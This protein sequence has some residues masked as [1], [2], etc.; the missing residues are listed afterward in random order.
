MEFAFGIIFVIGIFLL[1][2]FLIGITIFVWLADPIAP[3]ILWGLVLLLFHR[4]LIRLWTSA[5][6]NFLE[7]ARQAKKK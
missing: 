7:G 3:F 2:M 5:K 4:P 1:A 6:E